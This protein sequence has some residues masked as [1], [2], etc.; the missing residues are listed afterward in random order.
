MEGVPARDLQN[1]LWEKKIR[2]RA[3]GD[4]KGV[5][6]SAHVYVAPSDIDRVLDVVSML[7]AKRA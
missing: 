7:A 5:R 1:A 3:Q 4:D 6:L 2:V